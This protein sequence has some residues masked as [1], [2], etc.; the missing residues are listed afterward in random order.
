VPVDGGIL[1][2]IELAGGAERSMENMTCVLIG[3]FPNAMCSVQS[4]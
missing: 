4:S 3:G 1:G 2:D